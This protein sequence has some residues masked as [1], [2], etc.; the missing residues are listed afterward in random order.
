MPTEWRETNWWL[1]GI[2]CKLFSKLQLHRLVSCVAPCKKATTSE[3]IFGAKS[4]SG[5]MPTGHRIALQT[6]THQILIKW[7]KNSSKN[8]N[9]SL[10]M[11]NNRECKAKVLCNPNLVCL[12]QTICKRL[13]PTPRVLGSC[14]KGGV[15]G[16]IWA[17]PFGV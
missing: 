7:S 12:T 16:R 15:G 13:L 9:K 14:S 6:Q 11:E 5:L 17:T 3:N 10:K 1:E 2:E 8:K 4:Y